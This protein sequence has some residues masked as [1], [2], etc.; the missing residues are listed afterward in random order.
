MISLLSREKGLYEMLPYDK[1]IKEDAV[2]K[3]QE[4]Q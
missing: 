4:K 1:A 3:R 2:Q